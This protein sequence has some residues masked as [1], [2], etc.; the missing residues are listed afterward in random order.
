MS[1][2]HNSYNH[3]SLSIQ[4]SSDGFS[5][6][7]YNTTTNV[8]E[9]LV[10][11][12]FS[13]RISLPNELLA[14]VKTVFE[15]EELLHQHYGELTLIH[16]NDLNTFVPKIHFDEDLVH[17]YLK[18]TVKTFRNDFVSYDEIPK[19]EA[20]N[21]YIPYVNINNYIFD[22]FGEF[23]YLHSSTVFLENILKAFTVDV[24]TMFVNVYANNFQLF[25]LENNKLVLHNHFSYATK[26]D[27]AY[28]ILFVAEQLKM[29]PNEFNLHLFGEINEEDPN[30]QLLYNYVRNILIYAKVNEQLSD[31]IQA[32]PQENFNLLQ[33][34]L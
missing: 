32:S 25:V 30:Y 21:V 5:F 16:H 1:N 19:V 29:N 8:Y 20:N 7:V 27:F 10:H 34:H 17:E 31:T 15:T 11:I 24:K 14:E 6:C 2:E 28:Y 13:K 18:N 9:N 26:E 4:L 3:K 33:L 12:P 23:T 22:S